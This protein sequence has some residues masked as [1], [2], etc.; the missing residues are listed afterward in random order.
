MSKGPKG[1]TKKRVVQKALK[2]KDKKNPT[3]PVEVIPPPQSSPQGLSMEEAIRNVQLS[4]DNGLHQM[5]GAQ[6]MAIYESWGMI[7]AALKL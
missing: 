2:K 5:N 7:K 6:V 3:S 4:L 1:S